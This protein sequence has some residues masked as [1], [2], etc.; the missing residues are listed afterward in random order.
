[1][2]P[3]HPRRQPACPAAA[4]SNQTINNSASNRMKAKTLSSCILLLA[5]AACQQLESTAAAVA[6]SVT[7][8]VVSNTYNGTIT[9]QVTGL[10][11]G[12]T[13][14]VQKFLDA[15]TNGVVDA[16]DWLVQQFSLTD[17][18]AGMAIGGIVNSNVPGD[19]D[20]TAGQITAQL[21]FQNGDF[22]QNVAGQ[23][24]FKL[25]SPGGHFAPITNL[26]SVTNVPYAQKFTGNVVSNR[27]S[28]T[29]PNAMVLLFGP[30]RPGKDGPGGPPV[31]GA[32]ANNAGSYS[33]PAPP[34]TYMPVA[35]KGNYLSDF[36]AAPV[37]TLGSGVTV[38]TNLTLTN[39]NS[40]ISGQLVDANNSGIALPG[41]F[42]TANGN[43]GLMGVGFSATNGSFSVG[44]QSGSGQWGLSFNDTS[45]IVH[46]Y[47]GPQNKTNVN[48]GQ[49]NVTL[50]VPKA[51]ALFYGSVKDGLGNPLP[52]IDVSAY[53]NN[54]QYQSDGYTD[55]N[56]KYVA[57]VL[58]GLGGND[59]W[60]VQI[61]G[62]SSPT[63]Y[64]FSQPAFSQNGGTNVSA[65]TAVQVKFTAL[66]ATNHITGWLKDNSGN[67]IA[68]VGIWA[69]ATINGVNYS[70]NSVSTD[71]NGN[72]W[73]NVANGTWTVGVST[74]SGC[75]D[76]LPGNDLPPANQTVVITNNNGTANF[77]ALS[78]TNHISGWLKDNSGNPI[79]GIMVWAS[80]TINSVNYFQSVNTDGSGNY[81][82]GVI[83]G[84]W[85]VGVE[86]GGG[87]NGLP[88]NYLA[89]ANQS[90]VIA[91][92]NGTANFTT[93]SATNHISGWLKD[94]NGNP[95][96]GIGVWA[97]ATINGVDY[98]QGTVDTDAGGNYSLN[99]A[100]GTWSVGVNSGGGGDSLPGSYLSPANQSEVIANNNGT[101]NFTTLL[102]TNQI[103]GYV[104]N[105]ANLQPI[106]NVGLYAYANI[107]GVDYNM[108]MDTD[109]NG[110]Y[111]FNVGSGSWHVGLNCGGG[112]SDSLDWLGFQCV[113]EQTTSIANNN[114]VINFS[115]QPTASLQFTT[116]S[117]P[118]GAVGVPYN[119][120]LSA[121]GGQSPYNW[122][123]PGGTMSLP[124][125]TSGDMSFSSDG[126]NGTISGT[127]G[128]AGTFSF[129]VNVSDNVSPPNV[130][131]QM[132]SITITSGAPGPLQVVTTTVPD[133]I[134]GGTYHQQL[135][136]SGGQWPY[137]WSLT[138]GSLALPGGLNL[139]NG[140]IISGT[141][142]DAPFGGTDYYFSVRVTDNVA[143]TVDQVLSLT[144]YP[145]LIMATNAMPSGTVGIAYSTQVLVSGGDSGIWFGSP[146]YFSGP[147]GLI[148][149][150]SLPPGLNTSVGAI[151]TSN[152]F[153]V[154]S[155]T[156]TNIGT[157]PF[158]MGV[159]DSDL[160]WVQNNYSITIA[161]SSLQITTASLS[162]AA[163]GIAYSYQMQASGGTTPYVWTIANGS[164][165]LPSA[166][167]L[168][169]SGLISGAPASSGTNNFIVRL[170]DHNALTVTRSL[171]L[172][173]SPKPA[174]SS[175]VWLTNRFQMRLTGAANQ[176]YTLQMS[177]NLGST[178]WISL[179]VTNNT[180]ANS[181]LLTDPNATNKLRFYRVLVGP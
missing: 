99:V 37:L 107:N 173:T 66:L 84:S 162:N 36:S 74:C 128:A 20:A 4:V 138:P 121:T 10:T 124:P 119:Q 116:G 152:A 40:S 170:T 139:S 153:F 25:S 67:P 55:A 9:L 168:S 3:T 6:F 122:W 94:N 172:I 148:A 101:A 87:G 123:L 151:T 35:F 114:A 61:S 77:T 75:S 64:L 103:S 92:N 155:G 166:L 27:T 45:L 83:N 154:I 169:A 73:L 82:L 15:N 180:T 78:A 159:F 143:N 39:A 50:A 134:V 141:S 178:N 17:G 24:A 26:F 89:P 93:L 18:Q 158:T 42:L 131:S 38:T 44:A 57:G 98:N 95:I 22:M 108:Y 54:N 19:T 104:T 120:A 28:A 113:S 156:P 48:A 2:R 179:F 76:G 140:G 112:A 91:N 118:P 72:Y 13:V 52:G 56:G 161:S 47:L 51:T 176:N 32:M 145:A 144:I 33:I 115:V 97:N 79:T 81:S 90:V 111:A 126:V 125:G 100:N 149:T 43:G 34:G 96:A 8:S 88:G 21:N 65:G 117:L 137:S 60:S 31:A 133:G 86:Q 164:Q 163:V 16:S 142:T 106:A 30:P 49:T 71:T 150:G 165:P 85:M 69:N 14:V 136:A 181:F 59:T 171:A 127:P 105:A 132:F 129:W 157:Y 174:L 177:T 80:A 70:Q 130:I 12:E 146:Y 5:V 58:G 62:D 41:I 46:G 102:A 110:H 160:N 147:G 53:D 175:P 63:N 1:M 167:T 7:P 11:N 68:S 109:G 29:L 23:Y 135:N